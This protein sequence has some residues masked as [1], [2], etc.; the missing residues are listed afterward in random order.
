VL[1][2]DRDVTHV[3]SLH[4]LPV[5][6][7]PEAVADVLDDVDVVGDEQVRHVEL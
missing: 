2:I 7:D 4:Q 1:R 6:Q 5:E 3:S